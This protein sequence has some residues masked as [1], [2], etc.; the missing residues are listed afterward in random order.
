ML[1]I[2]RVEMQRWNGEVFLGERENSTCIQPI[3]E[4]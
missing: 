3:A 2:L 1:L 4:V